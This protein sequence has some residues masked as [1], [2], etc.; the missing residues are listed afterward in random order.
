M[1][2]D[3]NSLIENA[4]IPWWLVA[5]V[6]FLVPVLVQ[7]FITIISD[8]GLFNRR[9]RL[10]KDIEIYNNRYKD[11]DDEEQGKNYKKFI[12]EKISKL[13][14]AETPEIPKKSGVPEWSEIFLWLF[15]YLCSVL[16][17]IIIG[18]YKLHGFLV[19]SLSTLALVAIG[20]VVAITV[21]SYAVK[22]E[23]RRRY[24]KTL[25]SDT[26]KKKKKGK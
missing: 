25:P 8:S 6:F 5:I 13:I 14:P 12:D 17:F 3:A 24:L 18:L 23:K 21:A 2:I 20:I 4:S 26:F 11:Q 9:S 15:L 1:N 16:A 7:G 22:V 10:L 19:G